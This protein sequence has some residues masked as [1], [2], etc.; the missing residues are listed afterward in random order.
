MKI[1]KRAFV[2]T[3]LLAICSTPAFGDLWVASYGG[4]FVEDA[5]SMQKTSDGGFIVA[6]YTQ[7]SNDDASA[8]IWVLKLDAN[9]NI[10]WQKSYGGVGDEEAD[11]VD[12]LES[13][14]G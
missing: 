6:G 3:L 9:G 11:L 13:L 7:T 5:R 14:V 4:Q 10:M 12:R 8:D 1:L 2:S